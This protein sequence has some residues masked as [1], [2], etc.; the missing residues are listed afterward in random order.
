MPTG[1][2]YRLPKPVTSV[3]PY[4]IQQGVRH[5][6]GVALHLEQAGRYKRRANTAAHAVHAVIPPLTCALNSWKRE[7]SRRR[8]STAAHAVKYMARC[9]CCGAPHLR[10]E[11]VEARAV[12]QACQHRPNVKGL[13]GVG[14]DDACM[15]THR[16][17]HN[18]KQGK[19]RS[20]VCAEGAFQG[21]LGSAKMTPRQVD[22][23]S[24]QAQAKQSRCTAAITPQLIGRKPRLL[25]SRRRRRCTAAVPCRRRRPCR[26][27]QL[28]LLLRCLLLGP[29]RSYGGVGWGVDVRKDAA[30]QAQ[31][32]RLV[33][34]QMVSHTCKAER[35]CS[36]QR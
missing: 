36:Q 18:C 11:F 31:R 10:L 7:P 12:Q 4:C 5:S 22:V 3:R 23:P 9:A 21:C 15:A 13:L 27:C 29:G 20:S 28:V 6:V 14:W 26:C 25:P 33:L 32:M 19:G 34:C 8:A 1:M 24:Q 2:P 30:G 35:T 17:K 16:K